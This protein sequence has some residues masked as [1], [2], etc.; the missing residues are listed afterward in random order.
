MSGGSGGGGSGSGGSGGGSNS[1]ASGGDG[2][3]GSGSGGN[4]GNAEN[5]IVTFEVCRRKKREK[6][7]V[8]DSLLFKTEFEKKVVYDDENPGS[9]SFE[10]SN[11]Q[12]R[13]GNLFRGSLRRE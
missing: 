12:I 1:G 4:A 3:G 5:G 9:L 6:P 10:I 7:I 8:F 11:T 13:L 2:S